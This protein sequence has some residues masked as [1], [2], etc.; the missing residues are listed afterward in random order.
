MVLDLVR[1]AEKSWREIVKLARPVD[2]DKPVVIGTKSIT[3]SDFEAYTDNRKIYINVS[4]ERKVRDSFEKIVVPCYQ[5]AAEKIYGVYGKIS[6]PELMKNLIL[7]TFIFVHFHEQFHPWLC[8]NSRHDEKTITKALYDGIR[9]AEPNLSKKEVMYKVNN[10]KNLVWDFVLNT[11]FIAKTSCCNNDTL[12]EKIS[13]VFQRDGRQIEYKP[14]THYPSGILP[15]VYMMSAAQHKTDISISLVGAMYSTMSYNDAGIR[16]KAIDVFLDDLKSKKMNQAIDVVMKMYEGLVTEIRTKELAEAGIDKARYK[17]AIAAL[18]NTSDPRYE[19]NQRYIVETITRIFDTPSFRYNALKGFIQP[20]AQ[21]ISMDKK[22]GSPDPNTMGQRGEG[23]DGEDEAGG[24]SQQEMDEDSMADTFDDLIGALDE[25]E[26]DDM[27]GDAVEDREG[28]RNDAKPSRAVRRRIQTIAADEFYKRNADVV[29]VRN[30]SQENM[31]YELGSRKKWKL[32]SS[33]TITPAEAA[34]L[35]HQQILNF[36]AKTGLPILVS[37]GGGYQK[38][39]Q[40]RLDETPLKSYSVQMTGIEMPDNWVIIQDSSGSM[41]PGLNYVGTG[42]K[43]DILNRVK[44]GIMKGMYNVCTAMGK[45]LMFGVVDF[46]DATVYSGL[47]SL[48]KVYDARVHPIK[49]VSLTPQCGGTNINAKVFSKIEK[50]LAPGKTIYTLVTDGEITGGAAS[51]HK[52]IERIASK[53]ENAFVFVEV[54]SSSNFGQMINELSKAKPSVLYF[55]VQRVEEIKDK[56]SSV[57]IRY[58]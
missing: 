9:K 39:N 37:L 28:G 45:D 49:T 48:A 20:I 30:L 41:A 50:D 16:Q 38:F 18:M 33:K 46:S 29:E 58:S 57:L 8:P 11:N 25:D 2:S 21:F 19:E 52:E 56:L 14:V 3:G 7:D 32:V 40:Y 31:S 26:L 27:L 43:F 23:Q 12:E 1:E 44:Y 17:K 22:Q 34:K 36:Q 42:C 4:N 6:K 10:C 47:D 15:V 53:D 55:S 35:N 24:K 13:Y 51:L 5:A 54:Q